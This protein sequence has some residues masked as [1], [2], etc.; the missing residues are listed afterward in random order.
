MFAD[1]SP[2]PS[3]GG[4]GSYRLICSRRL[5]AGAFPATYVPK[6]FA[7]RGRRQV[8]V[9]LLA[10]HHHRRKGATAETRHGMQREEAILCRLAD[11]DVQFIFD[12]ADDE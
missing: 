3:S 10:H 7:R 8:A 4:P 12:R 5:H 2:Y 11:C 6:Q 9:G 1:E